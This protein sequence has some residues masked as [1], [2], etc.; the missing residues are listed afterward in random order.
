MLKS[1]PP[2]HPKIINDA[3]ELHISSLNI[4]GIPNWQTPLI[5]VLFRKTPC[6]EIYAVKK[7]AKLTFF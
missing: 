7:D 2:P 1:S 5:D 4:D 6:S 3:I